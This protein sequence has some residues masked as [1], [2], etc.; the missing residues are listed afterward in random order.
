MHNPYRAPTTPVTDAPPPPRSP[1]LAVLAGVAVDIG[2]SVVSSVVIGIVYYATLASR[3]GSPEEIGAA[4]SEMGSS[5]GYFVVAV[6]TGLG[7][8]VLGGYVC[9]RVARRKER[10]LA[11]IAG[12]LSVATGL[13]IGGASLGLWGNA[14]MALLSFASVMLGGEL[15]RRRNVAQARGASVANAA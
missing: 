13:S 3:G 8:S 10:R 9:A 6:A 11:A 1:I 12:L 7:F 15:G 2:G 14:G 5:S 4:L